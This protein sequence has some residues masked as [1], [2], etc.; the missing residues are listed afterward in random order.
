[1]WAAPGT[2]TARSPLEADSVRGRDREENP[3]AGMG[4]VMVASGRSLFMS[5]A[6]AAARGGYN[7]TE[8]EARGEM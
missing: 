1:M 2:G 3:G 7:E 6:A 5:D 4:L 8:S